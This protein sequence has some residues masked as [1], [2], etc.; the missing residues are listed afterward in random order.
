MNPNQKQWY[1]KMDDGLHDDYNVKGFFDEYRWASNF[2]PCP[3]VY[4]GMR[5]GSVEAAYQGSKCK[6]REDM[7][8]FVGMSASASKRLGRAVPLR[9][10]WNDVK[11]EIMTEIVR[12]KFMQ[13]DDLASKLLGTGNKHLE[14]TNWWKDQFWGV[15]KGKGRNELGKILMMIREELRNTN[16]N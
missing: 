4:K 3:V 16:D 1:E 7:M 6:T 14:E 13:N 9:E 8:L 10:D 15:C 2:H 12:A 11:I 5:F